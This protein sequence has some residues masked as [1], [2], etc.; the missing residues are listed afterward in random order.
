[1]MSEL[2]ARDDAQLRRVESAIAAIESRPACDRMRQ[3]ALLAALHAER[4]MLQVAHAAA[5]PRRRVDQPGHAA[6]SS[7]VL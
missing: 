1:M 7:Q 2:I 3:V 6:T 5:G 4:A